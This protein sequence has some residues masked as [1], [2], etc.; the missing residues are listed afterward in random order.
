MLLLLSVLFQN[1]HDYKLA[2]SHEYG[3]YMINS[4]NEV[5]QIFKEFSLIHKTDS[6]PTLLVTPQILVDKLGNNSCYSPEYA[7]ELCMY[8]NKD[9]DSWN[10]LIDFHKVISSLKDDPIPELVI[11]E[12]HSLIIF[13]NWLW[14][15]PSLRINN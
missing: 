9:T 10:T 8:L 1:P 2:L 7:E 11:T 13:L 3:E 4:D 15:L 12:K 6:N 14:N 5:T